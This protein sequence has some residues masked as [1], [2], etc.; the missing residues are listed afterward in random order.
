MQ[1]PWKGA[2][3]WLALHGLLSLLSY[4]TQDHQPRD[5]TAHSELG[6][7]LSITNERNAFPASLQPDLMEAFSKLKFPPLQWLLLVSG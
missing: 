1:R 4:R 5:G 6:P 2:A 3:Y 7:P